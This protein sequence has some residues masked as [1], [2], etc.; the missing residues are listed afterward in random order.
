MENPNEKK[1]EGNDELLDD[2]LDSECSSEEV[3]EAF[4]DEYGE[5]EALEE[6]LLNF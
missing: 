5:L 3:F 2:L 6:A 4:L 1:Y